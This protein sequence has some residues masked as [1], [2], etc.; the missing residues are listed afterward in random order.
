MLSFES[1]TCNDAILVIKM[2]LILSHDNS[3]IK[4]SFSI[5]EDYLW[6]QERRN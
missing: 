3:N 6:E 2:V 4:K 5:A 1:R